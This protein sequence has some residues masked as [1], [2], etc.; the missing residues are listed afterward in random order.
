MSRSARIP[1]LLLLPVLLAACGGT[2]IPQLTPIGEVIPAGVSLA[3]RWQLRTDV[4]GP[5]GRPTAGN[6][7]KIM[8]PD[9][10]NR[11]SR[12]RGSD[13]GPSVQVFLETGKN[14]KITQTDYALFISFNRSVVEEYR[15]RE[16]RRINVGPIHADRVSGW[17]D[18]RYV[19][20]TL[21][22]QGA[23]LTETYALQ[24]DGLQLLRIATIEYKERETL[25]LRQVFDRRD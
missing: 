7:D 8:V 2:P 17:V 18:G 5:A 24:D 14:L 21:D 25:S 9:R 16:H 13:D 3:G 10:R 20:Q 1:V 6:D 4:D 19:I 15:F 11:G 23:Q 12:S 22:V